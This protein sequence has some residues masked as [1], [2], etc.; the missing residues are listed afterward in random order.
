MDIFSIAFSAMMIINIVIAVTIIFLERKDSSATL[1]WLV[2]LFMLPVIGLLFYITFS[3]NIARRTSEPNVQE[4]APG[5]FSIT[6]TN[7]TASKIG[8]ASCRERV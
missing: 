6:Q 4:V 5:D 1:A 2:V 7:V 3:Q 8:R